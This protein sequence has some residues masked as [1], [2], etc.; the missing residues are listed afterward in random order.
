[1]WQ[2]CVEKS[3]LLH[4]FMNDIRK[5]KSSSVPGKVEN[6]GNLWMIG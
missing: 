3:K 5:S 6:L 1:M 4:D 2:R